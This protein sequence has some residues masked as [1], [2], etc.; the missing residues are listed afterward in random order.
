M[1]TSDVTLAG[2]LVSKSQ[3]SVLYRASRVLITKRCLFPEVFTLFA[4]GTTCRRYNGAVT[5]PCVSKEDKSK[6]QG[7]VRSDTY[8]EQYRL[9]GIHGNKLESLCC[10]VG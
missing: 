3:L 6:G 10:N 2:R 8:L 4:H 7:G 5:K 1:A 9:V